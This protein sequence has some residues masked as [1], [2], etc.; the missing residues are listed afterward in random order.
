MEEIKIDIDQSVDRRF[1]D[2]SQQLGDL[3]TDIIEKLGE[4]TSLNIQSVK[5]GLKE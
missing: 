1:L 4:K 5:H 3:R 2:L